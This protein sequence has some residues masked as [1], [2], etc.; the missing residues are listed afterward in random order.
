MKILV[1]YDGSE[2]S[3]RALEK[4]HQLT[5]DCG[6]H[7]VTLVHSYEENYWISTS[8]DGYA[9][10]PESLERLK[11]LEKRKID[12][13]KEDMSEKAKMFDDTNASVDIRIAQ[14]YPAKVITKIAE[15]G[16]YDMIIIGNRGLGGLRKVV[17]G[18]VSNAV[19][20][21]TNVSVLVVK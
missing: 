21:G 19:I 16:G 10:T 9:P 11:D 6:I 7:E 2:P 3:V 12:E 1:C 18:S 14:G 13:K 8:A 5:S 4:A 17:L 20:Q 15:E